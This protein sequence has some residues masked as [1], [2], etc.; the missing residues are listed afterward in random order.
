MFNKLTTLSSPNKPEKWKKDGYE[1]NYSSVRRVSVIL[2]LY[3]ICIKFFP[4]KKICLYN[5]IVE[6]TL[7]AFQL[8]PVLLSGR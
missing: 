7:L 4:P 3:F 2:E 8:V 5:L 1:I 6:V